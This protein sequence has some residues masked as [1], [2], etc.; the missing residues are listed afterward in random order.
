MRA[1]ESTE[2]APD[3]EDDVLIRCQWR[4]KAVVS[5]TYS[6]QLLIRTRN[7]SGVQLRTQVVTRND[8]AG[9]TAERSGR[10]ADQ[11]SP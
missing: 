6:F 4:L 11:D 2:K 8:V 7:P 5:T 1:Q 10:S 9:D 3:V